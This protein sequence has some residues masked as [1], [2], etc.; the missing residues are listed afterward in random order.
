MKAEKEIQRICFI[1][2]YN[3]YESKR[4]FA[5]KFS[6]AL[7][8]KGV[9]TKI[10]DVEEGALESDTVA[11][12]LRFKPDI[13]CSFNT[14][15]PISEKQFLWDYIQTPH[16][17]IVVDPM[18]YYTNMIH[19]PYIIISCV[20]RFDCETLRNYPFENTFFFPHAIERELSGCGDKE[21]SYDVVFLGSCYDYESLRISWRLK[22]TEPINKVLDDAIDIVLSDKSTSISQALVTAWN[23]S[24]LSPEGIDFYALFFYVDQYSRGKDRVELI[25]SIKDAKVH[26]FGDLAPGL[27]A[28]LGWKPYLSS[29]KNV[30]VHPSVNFTQSLEILKKSKIALNSMPFFKN[31]S[32]ERVFAALGSGALPITM[33]NLF[34]SEF[35]VPGKELET[36]CAGRWD[37][38]N[39][40]VNTYLSNES[41]RK[42]VVGAGAEKV[43]QEHTWD[44]RADFALRELPSI[45]KNIK[46]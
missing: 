15:N 43:L 6:E 14:I 8:R 13:T 12:I 31:G 29:S 33:D 39:E 18:I 37:G 35:F 45:L 1:V 22:N 17:F 40:K 38:V 41:L 4:H 44:N 3:L 36:Y 21:K 42:E 16:W 7:E 26:V 46:K 32:H 30:T 10:I 24:K 20:D 34:W 23:V 19:S 9:E 28:V 27:D 2:N 5:L 11:S 25:R